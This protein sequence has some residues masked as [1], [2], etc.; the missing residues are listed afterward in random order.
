MQYPSRDARLVVNAVA[1]D[2]EYHALTNFCV[3]DDNSVSVWFHSSPAVA[4]ALALIGDRVPR[5]YS[6]VI[7][8]ARRCASARRMAFYEERLE[9]EDA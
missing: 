2:V 3:D 1:R 9:L 5:W 6:I 4:E 8:V 7:K